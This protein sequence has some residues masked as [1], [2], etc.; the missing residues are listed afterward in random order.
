MRLELLTDVIRRLRA[1]IARAEWEDEPC[2]ALRLQ[3][4]QALR[5]HARGEVFHVP[6]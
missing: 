5:E 4:E 6:F 1:E 3:L 2:E